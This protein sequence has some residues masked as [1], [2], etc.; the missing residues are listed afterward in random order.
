MYGRNLSLFLVNELSQQTPEPERMFTAPMIHVRLKYLSSW[1][2]A[3]VFR[4]KE[5]LM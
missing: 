3:L 5:K 2:F 1:R 4:V